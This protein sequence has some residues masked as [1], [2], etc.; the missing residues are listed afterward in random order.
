MTCGHTLYRI[1]LN[2]R[3]VP[4]VVVHG[5]AGTGKTMMAMSHG[6]NLV[7]QGVYKRAVM[8]FPI[9]MNHKLVSQADVIPL[10]DL[11]G[12]TLDDTWILADEM[13]LSSVNE[14]K[15]LMTRVGTNTKMVISGNL[16]MGVGG[17]GY[18][19]NRLQKLTPLER[20]KLIELTEEDIVRSPVTRDLYHVFNGYLPESSGGN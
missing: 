5:P 20:I 19:V 6:T 2:A 8:T 13:H 18:I 4:I 10:R 3:N 1:L 7:R 16:S 11:V 9:H 15:M 12:R 14:M 17:L